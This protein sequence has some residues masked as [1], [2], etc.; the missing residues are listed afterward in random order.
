M[1]LQQMV[2]KTNSFFSE[3]AETMLHKCSFLLQ[4]LEKNI[5]GRLSLIQN[6]AHKPIPDSYINP[7]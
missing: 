5:S 1:S 6:N 7:Q 3:K 4:L 2:D